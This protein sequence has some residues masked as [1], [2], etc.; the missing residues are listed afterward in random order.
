MSLG[1]ECL[2]APD[3]RRAL[4]LATKLD[5]LNRERRDIEVGMQESALAMVAQVEADD[6]YTLS[7]HRPEWHT[8]VV[9][10]LASRL[11]DR[12]HR[13]VFAFATETGGRLKGSGRSI[14]GLHLRDALD[15]VDKRRP[16]LLERF[17][18]HSA[19]AGVTL[20]RDG[21]EEFRAAFESVARAQL[22]PTDLEQRIETDGPLTADELTEDFAQL[23]RQQVWGQGF[24]EPRFTAR[25]AVESQRVVG[26]KHL[27]LM[28]TL[29]GHR[30]SAIRFGSAD[31]LPASVDVVYRLDVNEYQGTSTLQLI[32]EHAT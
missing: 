18:G 4:E 9:G 31:A 1:I 32:V 16:G 28:L 3:H 29:D 23:L 10:L 15:L 8:G 13:P 17:G 25:F 14:A 21:L 20:C 26:E 22:T 12:F 7:I 2:I 19:A 27:K 24:P 11:K 5:R 6:A 30:Y